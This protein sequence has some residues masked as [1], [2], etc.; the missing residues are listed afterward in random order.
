MK[1]NLSELKNSKPFYLFDLILYL[2]LIAFIAAAFLIVFANENKGVSQGFYVL[3]DN[4]IA[5]EYFYRDGN[6]K[7]KDGYVAHFSEEG[8]KIFFYPNNDDYGEYNLIA[9]DKNKKTIRILD[10]TCAGK[11]CVFQELSETGGFIYCAPHK[12]KIVPMGF[13]NPVSG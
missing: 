12:L 3:Y 6:F 5:A 7:I 8:D 11:D 1:K 10:A 2:L 9:V 13:T 4:E